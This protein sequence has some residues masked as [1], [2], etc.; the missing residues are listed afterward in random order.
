MRGCKN[1]FHLL[2]NS[3][4]AGENCAQALVRPTFERACAISKT[5]I[6]YKIVRFILRFPAPDRPFPAERPQVRQK[7]ARGICPDPS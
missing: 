3:I 7:P 1:F 6:W 2:C 4:F 5:S